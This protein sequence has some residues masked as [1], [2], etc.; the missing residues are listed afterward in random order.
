MAVERFDE[1]AAVERLDDGAVNS[2]RF[3]F[4]EPLVAGYARD[5]NDA[6][7]GQ[8][9]PEA[10]SQCQAVD[11]RHVDIREHVFDFITIF[12]NSNQCLASI[13]RGDDPKFEFLKDYLEHV[14]HALFVVDDQA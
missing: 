14:A 10:A 12:P 7:Q 2:E 8:D 13:D 1:F 6:G 5:R 11:D 4:G 9:F 3:Q